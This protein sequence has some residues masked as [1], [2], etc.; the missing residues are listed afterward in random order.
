MATQDRKGGLTNVPVWAG[1]L[2]CSTRTQMQLVEVGE[3]RSAEDMEFC[4][5]VY[6]FLW[7]RGV[8]E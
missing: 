7:T 4:R 5:A 6:K 1:N 3:E 8:G 2:E